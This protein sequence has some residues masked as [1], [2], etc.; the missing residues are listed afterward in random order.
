MRATTNRAAMHLCAAA[1]AMLSSGL[2]A[3]CP[4]GRMVRTDAGGSTDARGSAVDA[5]IAATDVGP[6][7]AIDAGRDARGGLV[8]VASCTRDSEC[9]TSCPANPRGAN[10]CDTLARTCYAA[11]VA[12]CP[13]TAPPEDGGMM[14][15]M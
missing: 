8:C 4:G 12:T 14:T 9:A 7:P 5:P 10:C 3:G 1:L 2:V 11:M 6:P 15:S 13:A